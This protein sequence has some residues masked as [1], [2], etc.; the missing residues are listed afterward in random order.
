MSVCIISEYP[1][2]NSDILDMAM[3]MSDRLSGRLD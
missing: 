2:C 1:V 3:A